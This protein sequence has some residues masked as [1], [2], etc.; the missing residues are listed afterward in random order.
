MEDWEIE[1][2][3]KLDKEL[4]S[5][6]YEIREGDFTVFTGKQG[7]IDLEVEIERTLREVLNNNSNK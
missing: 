1:L 7:K 2:R 5:K 3:D 6:L 4:E